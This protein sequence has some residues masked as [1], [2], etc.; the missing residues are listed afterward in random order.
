MFIRDITIHDYDVVDGYMQKLHN[1]H[2]K[3]RP[4][5]YVYLEHPYSEEDF[6][7]KVEDNNCISILA[8]NNGIIVGICFVSIRN[9]SN[10]VVKKIAYMDE[11]YVNEKFRHMGIAKKL[12]LEAENRAIQMGAERLDLMVWEFNDVAIKFYESLG[13]K[14]QR[15]ILEKKL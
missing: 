6:K 10:M 15:Y 14:A 9:K 3:A 11:L 2:V 1:L 8:E 7:I 5:L 12:Y 13:M 4:D